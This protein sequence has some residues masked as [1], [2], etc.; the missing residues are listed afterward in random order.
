MFSAGDASGEKEGSTVRGSGRARTKSSRERRVHYSTLHY[1][2]KMFG[3]IDRPT[4]QTRGIIELKP[5]VLSMSYTVSKNLVGRSK[6]DLDLCNTV[7]I[8]KREHMSI[9]EGFSFH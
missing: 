5:V 4:F 8:F 9:S 1:R 3:N 6:E 7:K 2:K